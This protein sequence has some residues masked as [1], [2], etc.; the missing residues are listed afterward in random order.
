M[1]PIRIIPRLDIKSLN[2]VKGVNMEG[3][4]VLG[5]PSQFAI[6]YYLDGADEIFYQDIVAS[7][8]DRKNL[9]D[10][11][12][13]TVKNIF[14]PITA[15]GGIK[16]LSQIKELLC[17]GADRVSINS[18]ALQNNNFLK[19]AFLKFG[20]TNIVVSIEA[21]KINNEYY[22]FY[23]HGREKAKVNM[24]DWIKTCE[25]SGAGELFITSIAYEGL[26]KGPDNHLMEIIKKTTNLPIVYH[27]GFGSLEQI[28][29]FIKDFEPNGICI[30]SMIHYHLLK[31]Q[32]INNSLLTTGNL[33]F[34]RK[35][36]ISKNFNTLSI[37]EIKDF[38]NLNSITCV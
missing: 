21:L 15:G 8:Y 11:L 36:R 20:S 4:R 38:L 35:G 7:L 31:N 13:K 27:G 34:L 24:I 26:G 6:N 14:I 28:L 33:D 19:S 23:N 3:L 29:K 37:R 18:H 10:I 30:S 16:S 1:L 17:A 12:S 5:D 2:L 9:I 32:K 25:E 22:P